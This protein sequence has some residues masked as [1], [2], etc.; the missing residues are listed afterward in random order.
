VSGLSRLPTEARSAEP[1]GSRWAALILGSALVQA[2]F[3][4]ASPAMRLSVEVGYFVA[5]AMVVGFVVAISLGVPRLSARQTWCVCSL[6]GA[7]LAVMASMRIQVDN[8][9]LA[10]LVWVCIMFGCS[11]LGAAVGR[12]VEKPGHILVVV[13]LSAAVDAYSVLAP[14]GV[15]AAVVE[16]E[17]LL[18]VLALS[19]AFPGT[20][21]VLPLLGM[22]DV[23]MTS[24]YLAAGLAH[25]LP[26]GR[27]AAWL[28]AGYAAVAVA[29]FVMGRSLPALPFLG[30]AVVL[31]WPQT[32]RLERREWWVALAGVALA[33]G[34]MASLS[35]LR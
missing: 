15:S 2:S 35:A 23:T 34:L 5:F 3:A 12:A 29:V 7:T 22:G 21:Q 26:R 9:G 6:A 20:A 18:S 8:I 27:C 24:L 14:E 31:A 32:R 25:A 30:V 19:W 33:L 17:V 28:L 16:N 1:R 4:F 10:A 11:A 13:L